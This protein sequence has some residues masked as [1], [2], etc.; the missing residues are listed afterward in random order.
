[1]SVTRIDPLTG[2]RVIVAPGRRK[3]GATRPAGLPQPSTRCPFCPGHEADTEPSVLALGEPWRVRVVA[4]RYAL[5]A[6]E[7][8]AHEVVIEHRDHDRDLSDYEPEHTLEVLTV[9][10]R[11]IASLEQ[12]A[13]S[14]VFFRNRGRRAGSSQPHPHAQIVALPEVTPSAA[15][16]AQRAADPTLR[17]GAV[18]D[19]E[20]QDPIA[21]EGTFRA[22]CPPASERA[23]HVRIASSEPWPRF[24]AIAL[25]SLADLSSLLPRVIAAALEVSGTADYNLLLRDPPVGVADASCFFDVL[26]R[27]GGDAG[28]ELGSGIGVCTVEPSEAAADMRALLAGR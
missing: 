21:R 9:A 10:Q 3:I 14:V 6:P 17:L 22:W 2:F 4:N 13:R 16:R 7:A 12:G 19:R 28:F 5:I 24:S 25:E 20:A 8:G 11:R 23:F 1:M 18:M 15:M 27:T 26:P